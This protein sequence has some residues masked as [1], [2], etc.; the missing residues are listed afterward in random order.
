MATAIGSDRKTLTL[1]AAN[2]RYAAVQ[3]KGKN[4]G[5]VGVVVGE[6]LGGML[7]FRYRNK[8]GKLCWTKI[9]PNSVVRLPPNLREEASA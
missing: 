5:R 4:I 8:F 6:H 7:A 1:F 2:F 3:T 9:L